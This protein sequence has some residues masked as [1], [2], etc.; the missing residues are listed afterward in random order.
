MIMFRE[1]RQS[2]AFE[3]VVHQIRESILEGRLKDGDIL[4]G[5]RQLKDIFK[6]SRGTLREALRALEQKK[7]VR[8][9]TGAKG[10]VIVCHVDNMMQMTEDLDLL[11]R[12]KKIS[13]R[14]LAEFREYVEAVVAEKAAVKAK[15]Q[16][17]RE[18]S[19]LLDSI[20]NHIHDSELKW[21][22]AIKEDNQFHLL[23]AQIAGNRIFSSVLHTVYENIQPY[24]D[25][26]LPVEQRKSILE[27]T[28]KDLSDILAAVERHDSVEARNVAQYHVR[29]FNVLMEKVAKKR[30]ED[31]WKD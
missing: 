3:D 8:I 20:K 24:W 5:E 27:R 29:H 15:S 19:S 28:H 21:D 14:E 18:L 17:I 10:G 1:A 9:K 12:Y 25:R 31:T 23:L 30:N 22:E 13:L 16:H 2:R 4:P 7:L 11:L 26:F 6:V